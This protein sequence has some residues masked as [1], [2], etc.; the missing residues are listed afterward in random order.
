MPPLLGLAPGG[1]YRA[2]PVA[3]RRGALLPHPF[4]L[5]RLRAQGATAGGLL[6]VAL[7]LGSPPPG[8]TRH[9]CSRGARTFLP[10]RGDCH[11]EGG[12]P[13][14]WH[15]EG[16]NL[17]NQTQYPRPTIPP[18]PHP[19][20]RR[21]GLGG[22]GAGRRAASLPGRRS[23]IRRR[24]AGPKPPRPP[25]SL[26][27]DAVGHRPTPPAAR[28]AQSKSSPGSR[29]RLGATSEWPTTLLGGIGWRARM[30]RARPS[31]RRHLGVGEGP[32]AELVARVDQLDPQRA[33][34][35]VAA[36]PPGGGAGV[37]GA[38]PFVDHGRTMFLP[39]RSRNGRSPWPP[40]RTG[41]RVPSSASLMPV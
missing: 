17:R 15:P 19:P 13:A 1:V 35:D 5:T 12:H 8:I 32:V 33:A 23:R 39:R 3:G 36:P 38:A 22:S 28:R 7:S 10:R 6:S 4:T 14:V 31:Q 26:G 29:L 41:G 16:R 34:V 30:S 11:A 40:D 37:P 20:R 9:R 2:A 25:A 27:S 21:L 24:R 18:F